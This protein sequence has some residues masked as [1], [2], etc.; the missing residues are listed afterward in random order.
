M[1]VEFSE[2]TVK[3]DD[4]GKTC[5][6]VTGYIDGENTFSCTIDGNSRDLLVFI[7]QRDRENFFLPAPSQRRFI[8]DNLCAIAYRFG[9]SV[10]DRITFRI[11]WSERCEFR[12]N[13]ENGRLE[14]LEIPF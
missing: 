5:V 8:S 10:P 3:N 14:L 13:R 4:A 7:D 9:L 11:T 12:Y 2:V 1:H 6:V